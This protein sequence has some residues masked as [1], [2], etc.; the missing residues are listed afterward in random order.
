MYSIFIREIKL[1]KRNRL[2]ESYFLRIPCTKR[3][4]YA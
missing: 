1:N 4:K 3:I 2:K